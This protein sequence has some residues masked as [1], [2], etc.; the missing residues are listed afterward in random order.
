MGLEIQVCTIELSMHLGGNLLMGTPFL[1]GKSDV[2][3]NALFH[4]VC[5][6]GLNDRLKAF[7]K[8]IV[9]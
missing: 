5:E 9:S 2:C 3:H 1:A 6:K 8:G 7:V 4:F